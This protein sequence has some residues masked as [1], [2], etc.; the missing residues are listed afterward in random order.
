VK[1][2][3]FIIKFTQHTDI[4]WMVSTF[5]I[6]VYRHSTSSILNPSSKL[7]PR[8]VVP[9]IP[10]LVGIGQGGARYSTSETDVIEFFVMRV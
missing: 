4:P 3:C 5:L 7:I 1:K 9:M 10:D 8:L 2:L 6:V